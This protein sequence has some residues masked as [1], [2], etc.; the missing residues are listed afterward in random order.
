[1]LV[2]GGIIRE[3]PEVLSGAEHAQ[4]LTDETDVFHDPIDYMKIAQR[5]RQKAAVAKKPSPPP[6]DLGRM[7]CLGSCG[8]G[9]QTV[10]SVADGLSLLRCGH[11]RPAQAAMTV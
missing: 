7:L 5:G 8:C 1:H 9:P 11:E 6:A 4:M 10:E 3:C 2:V